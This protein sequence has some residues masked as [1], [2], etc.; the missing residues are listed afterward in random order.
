[1]TKRKRKA[2]PPRIGVVVADAEIDHLRAAC[3]QFDVICVPQPM[4][5][6]L[7]DAYAEFTQLKTDYALIREVMMTKPPTATPTGD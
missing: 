7:L 6:T 2:K 5:V 3:G 4:L 1:M